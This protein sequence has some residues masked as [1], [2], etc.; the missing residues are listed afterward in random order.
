MLQN[1]GGTDR[2]LRV[3]FALVLA[4]GSFVAPFS[5]TLR[6]LGFALPALYV[7]GTALTGTC[8]GYK[9]MGRSTCPSP[10]AH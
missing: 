5:L 2:F 4:G 6:L 3:T 1:L 10:R 8:L 9:L 7:L